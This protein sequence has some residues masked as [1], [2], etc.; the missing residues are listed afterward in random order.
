MRC[1]PGDLAVVLN[2]SVTC[3][4]FKLVTVVRLLP[5]VERDGLQGYECGYPGLFPAMQFSGPVWQVE[6]FGSD[7]VMVD[8]V[9]QK[10][11]G[12][13]T[14]PVADKD[15]WPLRDKPGEDEA[16]I[17]AYRRALQDGATLEWAEWTG[18]VS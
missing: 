14:L 13:R 4:V 11:E 16:V 9:T 1:K 8:L 3:N 18:A 15:L 7:L 6:S 5:L 12:V 10:R 2:S 17:N